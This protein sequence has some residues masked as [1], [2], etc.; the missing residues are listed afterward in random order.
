LTRYFSLFTPLSFLF[1][2]FPYNLFIYLAFFLIYFLYLHSCFLFLHSLSP[3]FVPPFCFIFSHALFLNSSS[4]SSYVSLVLLLSP[5]LPVFTDCFS[6]L[7]LG[8]NC[9]V[10]R[11]GTEVILL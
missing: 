11:V 9:C 3:L 4:L 6:L 5:F 8:G 1:P 7:H 2:S 10:T